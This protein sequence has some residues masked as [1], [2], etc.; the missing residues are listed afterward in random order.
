RP[1]YAAGAVRHAL[2][3]T[4]LHRPVRGGVLAVAGGRPD[5]RVPGPAGAPNARRQ[6]A[7]RRVLLGQPRAPAGCAAGSGAP[8]GGAVAAGRMAPSGRGVA[9]PGTVT[10]PG[11]V[12]WPA[13]VAWPGAT[14]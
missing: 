7:G 1:A 10:W 5:R 11:A 2:R 8:G 14:G 6:P 13:A 12:T 9:P 3:P 4:G